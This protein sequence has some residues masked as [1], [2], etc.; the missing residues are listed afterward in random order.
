MKTKKLKSRKKSSSQR[1]R[2][3]ARVYSNT[4]QALP[5]DFELSNEI[6]SAFDRIENTHD[7]VFL[8]GEAGTGK[9]TFLKYFRQ[10]SK[11]NFVVLAPTGIA[12][13][14][15]GGQTIH[16][17]FSFPINLIREKDIRPLKRHER[18]FMALQ[19]VIIDEAS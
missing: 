19:L 16:S 15:I 3:A 13:I 2:D 8:T 10:H 14:N 4:S 12:G 1:S 9:T 5:E 18:L 6:R 17:F 11:K 7:H